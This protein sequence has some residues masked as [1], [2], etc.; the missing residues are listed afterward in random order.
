M[1]ITEAEKVISILQAFVERKII[2]VRGIKPETKWVDA[3]E[4]DLDLIGKV[5]NAEWRIKPEP[6]DGWIPAYAVCSSF[7]AAKILARSML[8]THLA[9]TADV[10]H[11]RE[12][13]E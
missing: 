12:V 1:T 4:S 5:K 10:I 3:D 13:M 11:V 9:Q 6:R 2:Q 7:D 8:G